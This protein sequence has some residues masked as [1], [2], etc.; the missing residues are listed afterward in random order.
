[1]TIRRLRRCPAC[2]VFVP[3]G[4]LA[5]VKYG[6]HWRKGGW[7]WRVCPHCGHRGQTWTFKLASETERVR[8]SMLN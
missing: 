5:P 1:M 4:E 3:G 8:Y 6:S 7:S 2:S